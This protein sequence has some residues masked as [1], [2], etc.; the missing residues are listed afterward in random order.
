MEKR[1]WY[2]RTRSY[3][4]YTRTPRNDRPCLRLAIPI[5]GRI[6]PQLAITRLDSFLRFFLFLYVSSVF[7][8]SPVC[9]EESEERIDMIARTHTFSYREI[10]HRPRSI[11]IRR[12]MDGYAR[13]FH[14]NEKSLSISRFGLAPI[15]HF[16]TVLFSSF[17]PPPLAIRCRG[18]ELIGRAGRV[19]VRKGRKIKKGGG[20]GAQNAPKGRWSERKDG[21]GSEGKEK[22]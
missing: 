14:F 15:S 7:Y 17:F 22:K 12:W 8:F 16:A 18:R 10:F 2:Q 19:R 9:I 6:T 20:G 13:L 5:S 1:T 3:Y 4:Y 11:E 21:G